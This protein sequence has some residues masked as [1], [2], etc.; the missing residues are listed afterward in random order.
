MT[1]RFPEPTL[2]KSNFK[3]D[4]DKLD[5]GDI[6]TVL[7]CKFTFFTLAITP[8]VF[9][10]FGYRV[11]AA[12][13][14][15]LCIDE[16]PGDD[17]LKKIANIHKLHSL[18]IFYN[19]KEDELGAFMNSIQK[20][21]ISRISI[22]SQGITDEKL[23]RIVENFPRSLKILELNDNSISDIGAKALAQAI[24]GSNLTTIGMRCN[25][26]TSEGLES[27]AR[28]LPVSKVEQIELQSNKFQPTDY[29]I[30]Y[31]NLGNSCYKEL[32]ALID[33]ERAAV[34]LTKSIAKSKLEKLQIGIEEKY[35]EPFLENACKSKLKVLD[36][37]GNKVKFGDDGAIILAKYLCGLS[38]SN[39]TL[40]TC[41]IDTLPLCLLLES[42]SKSRLTELVFNKVPL[43]LVTK[44]LG[45]AIGESKLENLYLM[46]CDITDETLMDLVDGINKSSLKQI[47]LLFNRLTSEGL[48][49]FA[50]AVKLK[51]IV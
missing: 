5:D 29:Y 40:G 1:F 25:Q 47:C 26:I 31:E 48:R 41:D 30:L 12:K 27:L 45:K 22:V 36:I 32:V 43:G 46:D 28:T 24:P 8:D 15:Y 10:R 16:W 13:K 20:T 3:H 39:L 44:Q 38:I 42:I 18:C 51:K 11:P 17:V 14:V 19:I 2:M 6:E 21:N 34:A 33:N 35:L 7:N 37:H 50:N 9:R 23:Q 4:L 49:A